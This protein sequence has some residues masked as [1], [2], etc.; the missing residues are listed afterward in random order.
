MEFIEVKSVEETKYKGEV[1]DLGVETDHTYTINDYSVHNSAAGSLITYLIDI[2]NIDPIKHDLM[3][4]R[5]LDPARDD[6]PDIDCLH[7]LTAIIMVDNTVKQLKDIKVGDIVLDHTNNPQKVL[8]WTTRSAKE[9]FEKVV[10]IVVEN[11]GEL[12][13]FICPGHH[14][15][16]RNTDEEC[17]VYDLNIGDKIKS[18]N[19]NEAKVVQINEV[20][21]N[22]NQIKLCDIQVENTE[23]FQIYPFSVDN[24]LTA[25]NVIF[26]KNL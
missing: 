15:M 9:G 10:E 13:S 11:G 3:F 23:T 19:R 25:Q 8:N 20:N 17:F 16:I 22:Y 12:G 7:E 1:Y 21:Y 6:L 14:R 18:F 2:T 5:F 24:N 4:E 26:T